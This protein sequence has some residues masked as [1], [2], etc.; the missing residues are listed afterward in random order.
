M[1]NIGNAEFTS[2]GF[3]LLFESNIN[4]Y[5]TH[6]KAYEATEKIQELAFGERKYKDWESFRQTR[7][8]KLR[9]KK[10]I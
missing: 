4:S 8:K 5:P 6:I 2:K 7:Y 10:T 3:N 1:A 9:N